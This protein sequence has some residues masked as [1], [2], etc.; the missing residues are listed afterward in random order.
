MRDCYTPMS[1]LRRV[2]LFDY[3]QPALLDSP[4]QRRAERVRTPQRPSH[5]RRGNPNWL[6]LAALLAFSTAQPA[7]AQSNDGAQPPHYIALVSGGVPLR[8]TVND[9]FDQKRLAPAFVDV[10]VGYA[11]AG[12]RYRHGFGLGVAWNLGHDGGY[13]D[14]I[15]AGD[16]LAL[17]PAYLA[18]YPLNPDVLALG[19]VGIP[20][21]V[22]GGRAAGLELGAALTYRVFAGTGLFVQFDLDAYAAG[23]FSMLASLELGVVIDYEVLP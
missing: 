17:M 4:P 6:L 5:M 12:E 16:Q 22:R 15:Y 11:L 1:V 10:L 9:K 7:R 13:T 21:L 3:D 18:Y 14:P 23:A 20:I 2:P 8:L 19:H